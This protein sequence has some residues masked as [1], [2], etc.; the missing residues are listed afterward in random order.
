MRSTTYKVRRHSNKRTAHVPSPTPQGSIEL[1]VLTTGTRARMTS[2]LLSHVASDLCIG[3]PR[4]L[5]LPLSTPVAAA[6][7]VLRAG[8][9]PF[10][11]VDAAEAE[12]NKTVAARAYVKISVADILCYVC[13]D[14]G[15]LRDPAA[16]LGRP[17]SAVGAGHGGVARRVDP[18]TRYSTF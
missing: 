15:N 3:R 7:A 17:V 2:S 6:L 4:V 12:P 16:A 10:V 9:D 1:Y 18:N 8:A 13:G 5:T 11:F 14:V